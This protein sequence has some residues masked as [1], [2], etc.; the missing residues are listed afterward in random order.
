[1]IQELVVTHT[2]HSC[3]RQ[4]KQ[5]FSFFFFVSFLI[6]SLYSFSHQCPVFLSKKRGQT[7]CVQN[8]VKTQYSVNFNP[9]PPKKI[10]LL[11]RQKT[12]AI[13]FFSLHLA[14]V[15]LKHFVQHC[16]ATECN[17]TGYPEFMFQWKTKAPRLFFEKFTKVLASSSFP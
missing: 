5:K 10:H 8:K 15:W 4:N 12:E 1:M 7:M 11:S 17:V 2:T 3:N 6:F 9:H 16:A 13:L 14:I